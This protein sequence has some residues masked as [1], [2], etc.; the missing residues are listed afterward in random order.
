MT[1]GMASNDEDHLTVASDRP[2]NSPKKALRRPGH[3]KDGVE[4]VDTVSGAPAPPERGADQ[5]PR[6]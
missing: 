1:T 6:R 3:K 4:G 2:Q 5:R